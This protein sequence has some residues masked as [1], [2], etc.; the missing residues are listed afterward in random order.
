M[1]TDSRESQHEVKVSKL[2]ATDLL[3]GRG[4]GAASKLAVVVFLPTQHL[5]ILRDSGHAHL[6]SLHHNYPLGKKGAGHW[7][8]KIIGPRIFAERSSVKCGSLANGLVHQPSGYVPYSRTVSYI[9]RT[10]S[11]GIRAWT[12]WVVLK[13]NPPP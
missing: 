10:F 13:T 8:L 1:N 5:R 2:N 9:A 3:S 12:L 7:K 6:G 4:T 11:T